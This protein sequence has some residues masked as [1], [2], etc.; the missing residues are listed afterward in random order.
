MNMSKIITTDYSDTDSNFDDSEDP[1]EYTKYIDGESMYY[2][3]DNITKNND[4]IGKLVPPIIKDGK[5]V[6]GYLYC[7]V[8]PMFKFYGDDFYKLGKTTRFFDDRMDDY[9]TSYPEQS[10]IL[11]A[12]Y[13]ANIH[14]GESVLF[15]DLAQYRVFP[16]RE[17]FKCNV[18]TMMH[19]MIYVAA[20]YMTINDAEKYYKIFLEKKQQSI[21]I[22]KCDLCEY[23]SQ[24][25]I[26]MK[27][28]MTSKKHIEKTI[29]IT[30]EDDI[31]EA[32]LLQ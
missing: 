22:L 23:C 8:N 29:K 32:K 15:S 7:L 13:V 24:R 26:C 17:F 6:D 12:V 2:V 16:N 31:E 5:K 4:T 1:I 10:Q 9:S 27:N 14:M 30:Q 19:A 3:K 11:Y 21:P 25:P 20:S 28:H 18:H